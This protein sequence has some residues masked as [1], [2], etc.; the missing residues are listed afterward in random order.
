MALLNRVLLLTSRVYP[1]E[2]YVILF[3]RSLPLSGVIAQCFICVLPKRAG[4]I[5]ALHYKIHSL[6]RLFIKEFISI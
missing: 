2:I 1:R 4:L 3:V 5:R 6:S